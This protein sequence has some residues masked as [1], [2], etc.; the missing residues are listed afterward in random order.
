MVCVLVAALAT[1]IGWSGHTSTETVKKKAQ[2]HHVI[3]QLDRLANE[4]AEGVEEVVDVSVLRDTQGYSYSVLA[5]GVLTFATGIWNMVN[6]S[7][8][9]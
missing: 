4:L 6:S 9:R 8:F 5:E 7:A 3:V 1:P 2:W